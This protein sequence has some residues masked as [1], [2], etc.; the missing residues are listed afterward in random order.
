MLDALAD[1]DVLVSGNGSTSPRV[2]RIPEN[3]RQAMT[4]QFDLAADVKSEAVDERIKGDVEQNSV[5]YST[6][7]LKIRGDIREK[8]RYRIRQI[9]L[10]RQRSVGVSRT[11]NG[12]KHQSHA[13]RLGQTHESS[14][15]PFGCNGHGVRY[16]LIR[17][18]DEIR[19]SMTS[20]EIY[21]A[22]SKR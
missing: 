8:T 20:I 10:E 6:Y 18:N 17:A 22:T 7:V 13:G 19:E 2:G 21:V 1:D 12:S 16:S 4:Q 15:A 3:L 9:R 5:K 11:Y 14:D